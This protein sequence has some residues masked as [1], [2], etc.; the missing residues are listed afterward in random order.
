MSLCL[1]T[2][3]K[4]IEDGRGRL[5][6]MLRNDEHGF[7]GFGQVYMTTCNPNIVKAW[8]LHKYQ[9]DQFVCVSGTLKVGIY[10]WD[11]GLTETYYIGEN[12]PYRITIP[13]N[14]WH[15]FMACGTKE[16]VVINTVDKPFNYANPDEYRRPF[17]D[18]KIPY[19]WAIKSF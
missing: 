9:T 10:D 19:E 12:S 13:P 2:P 17:D 6:E 3:L 1:K 14:L 11:S 4:V 18:K 15:G 5:M 16:A 7:T 8:H